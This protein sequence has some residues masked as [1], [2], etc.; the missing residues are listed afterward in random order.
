MRI[1]I[2]EARIGIG[3]PEGDDIAAKLADGLDLGTTKK[4]DYINQYVTYRKGTPVTY[5][6]TEAVIA[7]VQKRKVRSGIIPQ[8]E[9]LQKAVIDGLVESTQIATNGSGKSTS[10]F[11]I[12]PPLPNMRGSYNR[13]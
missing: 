5:D 7:A 3:V 11:R 1:M 2:S 8:C 4:E 13:W 6:S 10:Y 12:E 9:E